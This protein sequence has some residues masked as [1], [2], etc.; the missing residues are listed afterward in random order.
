MALTGSS[1]ARLGGGAMVAMLT[2]GPFCGLVCRSAWSVPLT[3]LRVRWRTQLPSNGVLLHRRPSRSRPKRSRAR[4]AARR[5]GLSCGVASPFAPL[6]PIPA[7]WF[8]CCIILC[9]FYGIFAQVLSSRRSPVALCPPGRRCH[10]AIVATTARVVLGVNHRTHLCANPAA[11]ASI[12]SIAVSGFFGPHRCNHTVVST[13]TQTSLSKSAAS[14]GWFVFQPPRTPGARG[15]RPCCSRPRS[16]PS[17]QT[18]VGGGS[19]RARARVPREWAL[20]G[21]IRR[22]TAW[23]DVQL[24]HRGR[25]PMVGSAS[26]VAAECAAHSATA[27][28]VVSSMARRGTV[29][30][31]GSR[32]S[33]TGVPTAAATADAGV[34]AGVPVGAPNA[35]AAS[36]A[37][38]KRRGHG[39]ARHRHAGRP[40]ATGQVN[41]R[42]TVAEAPPAWRRGTAN[43]VR[44]GAHHVATVALVVDLVRRRRQ[45]AQ[46]ACHLGPALAQRRRPRCGGVANGRKRGRQGRHRREG[47]QR[48]A[49]E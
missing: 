34:P 47:P 12:P 35:V 33:A 17:P 19:C 22:A 29:S 26:G 21:A 1:I 49:A 45:V 23:I 38:R 24:P 5:R 28:L 46:A 39:D 10:G 20:P 6:R 15:R 11:G 27:C 32:R 37:E 30:G 9:V 43:H 7:P 36:A 14:T 4:A 40:H 31:D 8:P 3:R 25:L 13:Q 42:A 41:A 2:D 44:T 48:D 18:R 16:R